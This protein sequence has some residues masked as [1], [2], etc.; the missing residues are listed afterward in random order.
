MTEESL[1]VN[2]PKELLEEFR[3]QATKKFGYKRGH[4]KSATIEAIQDW[5]NKEK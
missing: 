2:V 5:I 4:I 1:N 3:E